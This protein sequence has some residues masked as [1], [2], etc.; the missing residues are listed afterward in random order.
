[1]PKSINKTREYDYK[2]TICTL[3][4][5]PVEYKEM[6][7]SFTKAGFSENICEYLYADNSIENTFDAF[8]GINRF[9][10]EAK[11][12]YIILCHQDIL[13]HDD[14]IEVLDNRIKEIDD[15]DPNWGILANAG[16]INLKHVAMHLTQQTG[17]RLKED[18][19]PLKALSVD[20]NF[21]LVKNDANLALSSD[22]N[23]FHLYGTDLCLIADILGYSTYIIDFNLLHKSDGNA[24]RSFY[25][26]RS[27]FKEKY[28][29]ALRSRFV[30][31][32]ITRFYVSGSPISSIV[33]NTGFVLF[34]VRQY[35]KLFTSKKDYHPKKLRH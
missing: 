33:G 17:N 24:D 31:T 18:H 10:Q 6:F 15:L 16:G 1:M 32:T 22:L 28:K 13:L 35:Y 3:V 7:T 9:L 14:N 29:R 20:E 27:A 5:D 8:Y 12:R 19:L 23:G 34:L 25:T 4:T 11:G 2:Y 30:S 21:I 26:L